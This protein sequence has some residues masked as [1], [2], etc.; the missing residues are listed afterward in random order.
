MKTKSVTLRLPI[1]LLEAIENKSGKNNRS[2]FIIQALRES[3]G[4]EES[5]LN[6]YPQV[7]TQITELIYQFEILKTQFEGI[8]DRV[9][10]LEEPQ[11]ISDTVN[12]GE[13]ASKTASK[14]EDIEYKL[15]LDVPDEIPAEAKPVSGTEMIKILKK[16]DLAG[17]WDS[18]KLK[19]KRQGRAS[20]KW[21][22]AGK[23]KFIYKGPG[24]GTG[25]HS[26]HEWWAIVPFV[27]SSPTTSSS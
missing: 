27:D 2:G 6:I 12:E 24:P 25:N 22:T 7:T 11:K 21:H 8:A 20:K 18:Q 17:K 4:V 5:Q 1:D 26:T 15:D 14:T 9:E 3:L 19:V 16:E 23:C 10:R 13:T